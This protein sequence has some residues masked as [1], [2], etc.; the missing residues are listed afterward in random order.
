MTSSF[1][2]ALDDGR[3][4]LFDGSTP[5]A[6]FERGVHFNRSFDH[7]NLLDPAAVRGIHEDFRAA[8]AQVLTTNTW[9]ANRAKL[10]AYGLAEKLGDINRRGA[11]LAREALAAAPG[12]GWVAGCLGP[13]GLR[14]EP[15]GPTSFDEARAAFTEQA[16]ALLEGGVDLIVLEA[17]EDLNEIRQAIAA[18]KALSD[19]PVVAMMTPGDGGCTLYGAEPEWYAQKLAEWGADLIGANGGG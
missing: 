12:E 18:V 17:F 9:A 11:A 7:E 19:L 13:L 3:C 5:T 6:L 16:E 2:Q 4:C 10:T 15:W 1:R 8:G 14:I